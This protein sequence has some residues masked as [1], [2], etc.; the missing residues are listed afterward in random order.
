MIRQDPMITQILELA[1]GARCVTHQGSHDD[2][3]WDESVILARGSVLGS[4][5]V[6]KRCQLIVHLDVVPVQ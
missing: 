5:L 1:L 4:H 2:H 6:C 3:V